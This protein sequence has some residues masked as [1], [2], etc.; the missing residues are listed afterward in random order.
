MS[1]FEF[2]EEKETIVTLPIKNHFEK[3]RWIYSGE[4]ETK[5]ENYEIVEKIV[6]LLGLEV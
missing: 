4:Y 2:I 1:Q 6:S 3:N 5:A